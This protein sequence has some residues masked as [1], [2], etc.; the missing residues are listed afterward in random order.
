METLVNVTFPIFAIMA[1]G[2]GA[3]YWKVLGKDST[4]ALNR[5][6]F[7]FALPPA[8]F[9]FTARAEISQ[10]LNW[11]YMGSYMLGALITVFLAVVV[12]RTVFRLSG[13]ESAF[14]GYLSTFANTGYMGI[15]LFLTAFGSAGILPVIVANLVGPI[16]AIAVI[17]LVLEILRSKGTSWFRQLCDIASVLLRNPVLVASVLGIVF[18]YYAIPLPAPVGNL[19]DLLAAAAGPAALFALGL[20]LVGHSI[21]GNLSE[22]VWITG[23][24]LLAQPLITFL[25]VTFVFSM[26]PFWAQSCVLLAALP[27]GSSAFVVS[28]QYD[29]AVRRTSSAVAISTIFSIATLSALMIYFEVS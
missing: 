21:F 14:H 25:L 13:E 23:L 20:S 1:L 6:V 19:L 15:P 11:S 12:A 24:K 8:M 9:I 10:I 3:G 27:V 5:F 2:Y 16:L 29:I 28:Q 17:F 4:V 26:D 18:S 22:I 7:T